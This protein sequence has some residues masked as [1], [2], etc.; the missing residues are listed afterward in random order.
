MKILSIAVQKGGTAK[1]TTAVNLAAA[2]AL[3]AQRVLLVD[4]DSQANATECLTDLSTISPAQSIRSLFL[5]GAS[6]ASLIRSSTGVPRLDFVPSHPAILIDEY[7]GRITGVTSHLLQNA[8]HN[9]PAS[10]DFV[11]CDCPPNLTHF[12]R[13]A[14]LASHYLLPVVEP[15][16]LAVDG[17]RQLVTAILPDIHQQNPGLAIL[18]VAIVNRAPGSRKY[19]P[20][21]AKTEIDQL[22][23][24]ARFAH[25]VGLDQELTQMR[26]HNQPVFVYAPSSKGA[27]DYDALT[28]EVIQRVQ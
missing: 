9:L 20:A 2:L 16:P 22:L 14:L 12:T 1:T 21:A 25:E 17:L 5:D 23:P 24:G 26:V 10:Y 8:L 27:S 13:N 3:R 11:V 6:I 19:V 7:F 4:L 15:E 18:G 28:N